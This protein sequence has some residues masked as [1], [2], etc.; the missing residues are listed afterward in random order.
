[1]SFLLNTSC[2]SLALEVWRWQ[3]RS[4]VGLKMSHFLRILKYASLTKVKLLLLLLLII[5]R[6]RLPV[7]Y[8]CDDCHSKEAG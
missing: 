8:E 1:M 7:K 2:R 6:K 5:Q 3:H 4:L